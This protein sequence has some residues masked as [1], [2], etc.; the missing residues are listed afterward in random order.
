MTN[1]I[2]GSQLLEFDS[3]YFLR[4]I[5]KFKTSYVREYSGIFGT[6]ELQQMYNL[7]M[8]TKLMSYTLIFAPFHQTKKTVK[9]R[10]M[11]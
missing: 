1:N 7:T 3:L 9:Y 11:I 5:K 10:Q 6:E 8:D 2:R 4:T